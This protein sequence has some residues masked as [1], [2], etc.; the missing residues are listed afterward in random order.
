MRIKIAGPVKVERGEKIHL[1]ARLRKGQAY[2]YV[3]AFSA[4]EGTKPAPHVEAFKLSVTSGGKPNFAAPVSMRLTDDRRPRQTLTITADDDC[5]FYLFQDV[6]TASDTLAKG[7][8]VNDGKS[9][10]TRCIL[11]LRRLCGN[12]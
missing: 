4:I 8:I 12:I 1:H 3:E 5:E 9:T 10:Y 7:R 6:D 2:A 11:A